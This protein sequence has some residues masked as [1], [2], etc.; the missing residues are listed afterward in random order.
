MKTGQIFNVQ[1]EKLI[2]RNENVLTSVV[3]SDYVTD[4]LTSGSAENG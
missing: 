4:Q 1:F 3:S 2:N